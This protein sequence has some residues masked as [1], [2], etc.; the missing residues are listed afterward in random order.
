MIFLHFYERIFW[1]NIFCFIFFENFYNIFWKKLHNYE[2]IFC[3][4][5]KNLQKKWNNLQYFWKNFQV[6]WKKLHFFCK[7]FHKNVKNFHNFWKIFQKN[8]KKFHKKTLDFLERAAG[9]RSCPKQRQLIRTKSERQK[10]QTRSKIIKS[11]NKKL[12]TLLIFY[13]I[14]YM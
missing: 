9:E 13:V 12:W 3:N 7:K 8:W 10:P 2:K 6:L 11:R 4:Y 14:I 5:V 1:K